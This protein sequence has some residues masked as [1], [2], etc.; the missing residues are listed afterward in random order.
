MVCR[1]SSLFFEKVRVSDT[2]ENIRARSGEAWTNRRVMW[3]K[4]RVK[5]FSNPE[6]MNIAVL[7]CA[8]RQLV[9]PLVHD[10]S[11]YMY[12]AFG[13]N[14]VKMIVNNASAGPLKP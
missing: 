5:D 14:G 6:V 9:N 12:R 2:M 11:E 7:R 4:I 3:A 8:S 10:Q 1:I 13:N